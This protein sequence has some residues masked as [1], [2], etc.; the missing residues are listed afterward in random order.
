MV[1][2]KLEN[3][4]LIWQNNLKKPQGIVKLTDIEK[5]SN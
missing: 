3:V 5:T 1:Q 2:L 4:Q